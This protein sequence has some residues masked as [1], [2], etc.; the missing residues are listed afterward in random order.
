[1]AKF[2]MRTGKKLH[3]LTLQLKFMGRTY[4]EHFV[5][6]EDGY[7]GAVEAIYAQVVKDHLGIEFP[8]DVYSALADIS[9]CSSVAT[10]NRAVQ[11]LTE[12]ESEW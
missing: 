6:T 12:Y 1:M 9:I 8:E 5:P 11:V 4:T 7:E 10:I 2:K 3:K